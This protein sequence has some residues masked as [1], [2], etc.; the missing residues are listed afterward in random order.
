MAETVATKPAFRDAFRRRRCLVP[1]DFFYEWQKVPTGKQPYA[2]GLADGLPMA[3]AGLWE[4]WND[5][6]T[7]ETLYTFT[8]ITGPPNELVAPIHN[9][10]PV[11]LPRAAWRLWLGEDE[12]GIVRAAPFVSITRPGLAS[13]HEPCAGIAQSRAALLVHRNTK[14]AG[15][16]AKVPFARRQ[17]WKKA[18]VQSDPHCGD[19]PKQTACEWAMER[20]VCL[21]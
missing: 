4:R 21:G 1:A 17:V 11:I 6:E 3:F 13:H 14:E 19:A 5:R 18:D 20:I 9:R 16:M 12:A 15:G 7:G 10:M 2:V 8:I